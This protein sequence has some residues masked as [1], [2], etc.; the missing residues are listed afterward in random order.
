MAKTP[1][2]AI[3]PSPGMG[4]L[5]PMAEFAKRLV[6][7][8]HISA[9]IIIPTTG[10][11]P[12]AQTSVLESLPENI[13]HIFLPPV[14][15]VADLPAGSRPEVKIFFIIQASLSSIRDAL[16]SLKSKTHLVALV[17][18]MFSH[19][20]FEIAQELNLFKFLFFPMNA[21]ALSFSFILPNLDKEIVCEFKDLPHPIKVPGSVSFHGRDLMAP[22]QIRTDEAYKGY[23]QLSKRL[24]S[25]DGI[26]V[27]SFQELEAETFQVLTAGV[28]G[29]S[30][31]PIYPIGPLIRSDPSNGSDRH[32]SL[33][34]LDHQPTKSVVLVSFGSGGTLSLDQIHELATGLE[35]SGQRFLWIVRSPN[36]KASNASFFTASSRTDSL[37]FLP[38]GFLARTKNQGLV[39]TSWAPQIEILSHGA[40]GGFLTHC[41]WNSVLESVVH[42]VPM[43][44]WP[45]YAEQHM[46]AKVMTE[47]LSLALRAETDEHGIVRKEVIEK[48][49][50]DLMEGDEGKRVSNRLN[51]LK[52]AAMK[53][54][55]DGGSSMESLSK[56]AVRLISK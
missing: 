16:T 50:K 17:F 5:I 43:I 32:E 48:V 52:V 42:G 28:T 12:K 55:S 37:G 8:H 1:H 13:H 56:F 4:H 34:W 44:A 15:T 19:D 38:Q 33:K 18:D 14:T 26:L 49:V 45:L 2:I 51:E 39:V 10:P 20:S 46:N 54:L 6:K 41:G 36:E 47:S 22:V 3:F 29:Q 27:N 21:M 31:T 53:A 7:H 23:L 24:T 11:P 25:L 30:Q 40:T 35:T 9:T